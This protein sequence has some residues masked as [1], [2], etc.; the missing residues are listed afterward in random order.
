M[1]QSSGRF[2]VADV[3]SQRRGGVK[4]WRAQPGSQP[5]SILPSAALPIPSWALFHPSPRLPK[6][7]WWLS[8]PSLPN[9]PCHTAAQPLEDTL[10]EWKRWYGASRWGY[11]T[12]SEKNN[13]F[14]GHKHPWKTILKYKLSI[15]Y[16]TLLS[17]GCIWDL[18]PWCNAYCHQR[19]TA[20]G[21]HL[22]RHLT[23]IKINQN[24][25]K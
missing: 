7:A 13:S 12:Q 5:L 25:M 24:G 15:K 6:Q 11:T 17:I 8:F 19:N 9:A 3:L 16:C 20:N 1:A 4:T 10:P 2:P 22:K 21:V 18:Q 23:S 14:L